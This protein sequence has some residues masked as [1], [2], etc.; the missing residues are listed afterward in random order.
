MTGCPN[1][2]QVSQLSH[3]FFGPFNHSY[4]L[5]ES[6]KKQKNVEAVDHS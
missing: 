2:G 3:Y 6:K 5:R 1:Q 4:H